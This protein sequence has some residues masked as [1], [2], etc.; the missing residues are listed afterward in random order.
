MLRVV[1]HAALLLMADAA[2]QCHDGGHNAVNLLRALRLGGL[3]VACRVCIY[4]HVSRHPA[5][6]RIAAVDDS[7]F[8]Q[9]LQINLS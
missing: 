1:V 4:Y 5:H 3:D 2:V 8:H 7:P 9:E 6:D